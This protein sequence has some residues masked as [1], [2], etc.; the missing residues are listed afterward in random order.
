MKKTGG[1]FESQEVPQ[2]H[3]HQHHQQLS[4]ESDL[5]ELTISQ[6]DLIAFDAVASASESN[7]ISALFDDVDFMQLKAVEL[8]CLK[9]PSDYFVTTD[10]DTVTLHDLPGSS[11]SNAVGESGTSSTMDFTHGAG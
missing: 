3:H 10:A 6:T 7:K 9:D 11:S 2:H 4:T 8:Q 5:T 1:S